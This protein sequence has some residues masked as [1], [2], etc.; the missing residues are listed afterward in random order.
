MNAICKVG[1]ALTVIALL[2]TVGCRRSTEPPP[3]FDPPSG[4]FPSKV[5]KLAPEEKYKPKCIRDEAIQCA[6]AYADPAGD[7]DLT[8]I[9]YSVYIFD[10]PDQAVARLEELGRWKLLDEDKFVW[11]DRPNNAG[12]LL[13][14]SGF[15]RMEDGMMIGSCTV[16]FTKESKLFEIASSWDCESARMF[17]RDLTDIID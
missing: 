7:A 17:L 9:Y 13:L 6:G 3:Q 2:S 11:E 15:R 8:R 16:A 14:R 10:K 4:I 5:G 12:K 1:V